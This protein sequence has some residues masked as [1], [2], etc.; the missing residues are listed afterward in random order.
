[1]IRI[2]GVSQEIYFYSWC[3][4]NMQVNKQKQATRDKKQTCLQCQP[5]FSVKKC[6]WIYIWDQDFNYI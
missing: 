4:R 2:F 3:N 5:A 6:Y 1:M